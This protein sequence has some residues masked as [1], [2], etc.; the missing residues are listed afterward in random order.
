MEITEQMSL[1][2]NP[3][4]AGKVFSITGKLPILRVD[5]M[6]AILSAGGIYHPMPSMKTDYIV[7]GAYKS[8]APDGLTRKHR[9]AKIINEAGGH[10]EELSDVDFLK[11][12]CE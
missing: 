2:Y 3:V 5:A 9:R 12:L 4:I 10:V 11:L 8:Q 1:F 7:I 6:E